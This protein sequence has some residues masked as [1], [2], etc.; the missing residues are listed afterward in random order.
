MASHVR[1]R[2]CLPR[3]PTRQMAPLLL[4][5]PEQL[6]GSGA[7]QTPGS[8]TS[9]LLRATGSPRSK[10]QGGRE[11]G[12]S[13]DRG[14]LAEDHSKVPVGPKVCRDLGSFLRPCLFP[15]QGATALLFRKAISAHMAG[16]TRASCGPSETPFLHRKAWVGGDPYGDRVPISASHGISRGRDAVG[17]LTDVLFTVPPLALSPPW[18]QSAAGPWSGLSHISSVT[19]RWPLYLTGSQFS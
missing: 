11:A 12:G 2:P 17:R 18:A 13:R 8:V 3:P 19:W 7:T 10:E 15:P 16:W 9:D 5:P 14:P 1:H 4:V 6:Q